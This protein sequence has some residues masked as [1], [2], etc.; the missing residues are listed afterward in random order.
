MK[1]MCCDDQVSEARMVQGEPRFYPRADIAEFDDHFSIEVELPGVAPDQIDL[2]VEDETLRL[3]ARR[4]GA[5]AAEQTSYLVRERRP[6]T[7]VRTF[8]LGAHVDRTAI[9]G[10]LTDGILK[11][12]L[13]KLAG[14]LP[15]RITIN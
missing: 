8:H 10:Q 7:F 5:D 15:R 13:P 3:V 9:E 11:I 2:Q 1:T 6:W 4:G 12:R 14:A